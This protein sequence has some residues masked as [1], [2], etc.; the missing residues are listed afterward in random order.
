MTF[1]QAC[2]ALHILNEENLAHLFM[3]KI[4]Y[5]EGRELNS[6]RLLNKLIDLIQTEFGL[7]IQDIRGQMDEAATEFS[8]GL[9]GF[10]PS[11]VSRQ[12]LT[13]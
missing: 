2:K 4:G 3:K 13:F 7:D 6:K 12:T 1:I 10:S 8:S 11:S 5:S 9:D